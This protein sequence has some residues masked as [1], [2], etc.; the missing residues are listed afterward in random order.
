MDAASLTTSVATRH[1]TFLPGTQHAGTERVRSRSDSAVERKFADDDSVAEWGW[2]LLAGSKDAQ[3]DREVV[4][5][6]SLGK[7]CRGEVHRDRPIGKADPGRATAARTRSLASRTAVSG[8]P[9]NL[10]ASL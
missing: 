6:P 2:D 9:D 3:G 7:V 1:G 10:N 5:R 4:V 8:R